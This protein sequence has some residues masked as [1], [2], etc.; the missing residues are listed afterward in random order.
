ML[1]AISYNAI[2]GPASLTLVLFNITQSYPV[3]R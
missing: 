3:I 2:S 1:N